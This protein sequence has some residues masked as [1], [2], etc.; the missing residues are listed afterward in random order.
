MLILLLSQIKFPAVTVCNQNRV[1]CER[2][3]AIKQSCDKILRYENISTEASNITR[4]TT[5]VTTTMNP[6]N[7]ESN[8]TNLIW[9]RTKQPLSK[10][11][12]NTKDNQKD[13][14]AI[15]KNSPEYTICLKRS[16]SEKK[17]LVQYLFDEGKCG[18]ICRGGNIVLKLYRI[19]NIFKLIFNQPLTYNNI[20][21]QNPSVS[22]HI[23]YQFKGGRK[24]AIMIPQVK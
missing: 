20:I 19:S 7:D 8:E 15:D 23:L 4:T 16:V 22:V 5:R 10:E 11:A 2:L 24:K 13:V 17:S 12:T 14:I 21:I 9:K 3:E 1:D 18:E 6:P